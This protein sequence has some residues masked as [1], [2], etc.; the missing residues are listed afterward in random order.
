[1]WNRSHQLV[2]SLNLLYFSS[3]WH[4]LMD[5]SV[6]QPP[7]HPKPLEK[8]TTTHYPKLTEQSN[9]SSPSSPPTTIESILNYRTF[10]LYA[11]LTQSH[12]GGGNKNKIMLILKQCYQY[13]WDGFCG[14]IH[15]GLIILCYVVLMPIAL[16]LFWMLICSVLLSQR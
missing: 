14:V 13:K 15:V 9:S 1:M 3:H 10:T 11:F 6:N 4:P 5:A 7:L 8:W 12:L 2:T 16:C